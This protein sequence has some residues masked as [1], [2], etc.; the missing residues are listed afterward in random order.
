[1]N[2]LYY[3]LLLPSTHRWTS[4]HVGWN[5]VAYSN[6][7][8]ALVNKS[9]RS[10]DLEASRDHL[11][12]IFGFG[13]PQTRQCFIPARFPRQAGQRFP[14]DRRE[15]C[16]SSTGFEERGNVTVR[17]DRRPWP[18]DAPASSGIAKYLGRPAELKGERDGRFNKSRNGDRDRAS[19]H[20]REV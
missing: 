15:P 6:L 3:C 8:R 11:R 19:I 14:G 18:A 20:L 13:R 9:K 2:T 4:V 12:C 17:T 1:M 10:A 5:R 7:L 16:T